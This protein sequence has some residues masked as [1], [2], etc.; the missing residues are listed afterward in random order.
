MATV[1]RARDVKHDRRVA[2]KV[3]N[4][5]LGAVL[6]GERFLSEIRV[7]ANLQH[8]NVLPL[9]DSGEAAGLLYYVMP[10]VDGESLRDRLNRE[11]QLPVVEALRIA[12][13]IANGVEYAHAHGVI[14]RDLKPENILLQ[15]GQPIVADFGIALAVS[16]AGGAR[17]TQ[18]GLSLGTP[19][20][21]SPEQ[22][23]GDR[24]IDAR[25][26]VYALGAMTYEMLVGE[27]PHTGRTSQAIIARLLT[28][29]PRSV[30]ESRPS[31]P[32]HIDGAI[33]RALEKLPADRFD[34]AKEFA[35]ALQ[36]R[37]VLTTASRTGPRSRRTS[38]GATVGVVAASL[39]AIG[40][41][42]GWWRS[43][44]Q[45]PPSSIR[46]AVDPP[47][48]SSFSLNR[49]ALS[50]DGQ[51]IAYATSAE[52]LY[53]RRFDQLE[54]TLIPHA[55]VR[56]PE[57]HFSADGHSIAYWNH[58]LNT[59]AIGPHDAG[60]NPTK[61]VDYN[62]PGSIVS[63]S[64]EIIYAIDNAFWSIPARGGT[65]R[66]LAG[67]DTTV[68]AQW[69]RG[70]L[71]TDGKTIAFTVVPRDTAPNRLAL[72]SI[73][74]SPR[75]VLDIGADAVV[76]YSDG[77]L[78]FGRGKSLAVK[79]DVG[80]R[81]ALGEPVEVLS[82]HTPLATG[83]AMSGGGTL[84]YLEQ[85]LDYRKL[86]VLDEFGNVTFGLPEIRKYYDASAS[87]DGQRIAVAIGGGEWPAI[88][89]YDIRSRHFAQLTQTRSILPIWTHDGKR[90]AF[91]QGD[92]FTGKPYWIP[93]D[94]SGPAE[95]LP[96]TA[97]V[98]PGSGLTLSP[99]DKY[100]L[101][102]HNGTIG[103]VTAVP[104]AGG[105]Q[106]PLLEGN[107]IFGGFAVSPNGKWLAHQS[108]ESGHSEVYIRA[109]PGGKAGIQV[110]TD[111]G[112]DPRWSPDGHTLYYHASTEYRAVTLD[113]GGDMPRIVRND[114]LFPNRNLV[115]QPI[116]YWSV[117][118][119]G[120][121]FLAVT[122]G[123]T[124]LFVVTNWLTEVRAKLA[125]K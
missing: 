116:R 125:G 86:E 20:Y 39:T 67:I 53:L 101:F 66:R 69:G 120:K 71:L 30:Q 26:D 119:D 92:P 99:D 25:S 44:H 122:M 110:S 60:A 82:G 64:S 35:D 105:A 16:N 42:A 19:Q 89:L 23:T 17:V 21:M 12:T 15:S 98:A 95:P 18:T 24:T 75:T 63:F 58:G 33:L 104:L 93:V 38:I 27:P 123:G 40:T 96:G 94:G 46:F 28:D 77:I 108:G 90:I 56:G 112:E 73:D 49:I 85:P 34:T 84:A 102:F 74:G 88:W 47:P 113:I 59:I 57:L 22:A 13:A 41:G 4:A 115:D 124:K 106:I 48:G 117:H 80:H 97:S 111:H 79:L 11:K 62:R 103:A 65:P 37:G 10:F 81:K 114:K 43:A 78:I 31:V 61:L 83:M 72:V 51:T 1:N 8:P 54:A 50:P 52:S 76:G 68:D 87:P 5:E 14:H 32:E 7:T 100:A 2:I 6:G 36:G 9:F 121:H 118:P 45:P 109:F 55:R 29:R 70:I 107:D 3:L 91:I